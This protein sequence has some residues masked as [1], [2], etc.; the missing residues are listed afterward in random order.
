MKSSTRLRQ[1]VAK[2][3]LLLACGI[4][5]ATGASGQSGGS[6]VSPVPCLVN[7]LRVRIATGDDNLRGWDGMSS[8][9]D[10]LDITVYF[11]NNTSQLAADVNQDNEWKNNTVHIVQINLNPPVRLNEITGLKL[12]HTGSGFGISAGGPAFTGVPGAGIQTADNWNMNYI[13]VMAEGAGASARIAAHGA[14]RFTGQAR[15]LDLR[16]QIPANSCEAIE[17]S[18]R[19]NPGIRDLQA[20]NPSGSKYETQT[21]APSTIQPTPR[22]G[23]QPIQNNRLIQQALAHTVQIGPRASTSATDEPYT[24]KIAIIKR[25]SAATHSLLLPAVRPVA[26]RSS[27]PLLGGGTSQMLNPQPYPPKGATSQIAGAHTMSAS[28]GHTPTSGSSAAMANAYSGPSA[29]HSPGSTRPGTVAATPLPTQMCKVGIAAVDG[30]TSGIWF[31]P[32]SGADGRFLI[33]GCGFGSSPG[34]VFLSGVKYAS[35]SQA[36]GKVLLRL[37]QHPDRVP[38]QVS[39]DNWS[40][41]QILAQIDPSAGGLYDTNNVT[42]VVTTASGQA[43]QATGMNFLAARESQPLK[44]LPQ[45]SG[46]TPQ[47]TGPACIPL[48]VS[49]VSAR[50]SNGAVAAD[51]ES[52]S[53]NLLRPGSTIAIARETASGQF[54]IPMS[55][56]GNFR[57]GVDSYQLTLAPGFQLD[58]QNGVQLR[59]ASADPNYCQ[60]VNGVYSNSGTWN[61]KYTSSSSFQI[62]WQEEGCWPK[63]A[64]ST[65]NS[66][67]VLNYASVSAYELDIAVVGPRGISPW[68]S[69]TMNSMAVK[70]PA[71]HPLL[72]AH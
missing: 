62:F 58:L 21:S 30:G 34:Q 14:M 59:H 32:V 5:A 31:S 8:S 3:A 50:S 23:S 61:V 15:F 46:C 4:L 9:K 49:L 39:P 68:P 71:G 28:S 37:A 1:Y 51:V 7:Y 70:Q 29:H 55:P 22:T 72:L 2:S 41:R 11:R 40:D 45:S 16:T 69:G 60:S 13:E 56:G 35:N 64:I 27:G 6:G 43:Y 18:A 20:A 12:Q 54:P 38:F 53:L 66:L 57:G 63:T 17:N 24:A 48:G 42:L 65:G 19:L 36:N 52:P 33:Q 44:A 67:E 25:Q 26:A 10:D 47:S